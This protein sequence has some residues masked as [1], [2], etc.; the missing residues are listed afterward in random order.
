[1]LAASTLVFVCPYKKAALSTCLAWYQWY[2]PSLVSKGESWKQFGNSGEI[3]GKCCG[4]FKSELVPSSSVS[5]LFTSISRDLFV[6]S[7]KHFANLSIYLSSLH[8]PDT[9]NV[10]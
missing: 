8:K 10:A 5:H 6:V 9:L 3:Q 7:S 2:A 1:M 4:P